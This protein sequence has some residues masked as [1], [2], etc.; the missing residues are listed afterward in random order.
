MLWCYGLSKRVSHSISWTLCNVGFSELGLIVHRAIYVKGFE[1]EVD[2]LVRLMP[3]E[4]LS[5]H[6]SDSKLW[7]VDH[8]NLS[9]QYIAV[10]S[11]FPFVLGSVPSLEN[12]KD[13]AS[14]M[15]VG[16][17]GGS[18]DMFLHKLKPNVS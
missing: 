5:F 17:G 9:T 3:P 16:L 14:V 10:L 15:N 6:N 8:M 2:T 18:I 4:G 13:T 7:E 11:L 1:K 12:T